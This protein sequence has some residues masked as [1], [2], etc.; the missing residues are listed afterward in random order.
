MLLVK[1]HPNIFRNAY[2]NYFMNSKCI[3]WGEKHPCM[4]P[5]GVEWLDKNGVRFRDLGLK[6]RLGVRFM[7]SMMGD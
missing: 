1:C 6:L 2:I 3:I 4:Q 5:L 7:G